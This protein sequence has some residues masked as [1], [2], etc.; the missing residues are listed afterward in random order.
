M[1]VNNGHQGK[2]SGNYD[3]S[4]FEWYI[5]FPIHND[6]AGM[7]LQIPVVSIKTILTNPIKDCRNL[8]MAEPVKPEL[9][10]LQKEVIIS[11][12]SA[13]PFQQTALVLL[14]LPGIQ[15]PEP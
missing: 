9:Q 11:F 10:A 15:S 6:N 3:K 1:F 7:A 14:A 2:R 13:W 12:L 4:K 8:M 5:H